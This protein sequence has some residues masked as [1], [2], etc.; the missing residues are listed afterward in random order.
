MYLRNPA[1]LEDFERFQ[2]M[3]CND[4]SVISPRWS[5]QL[6]AIFNSLTAGMNLMLE[7]IMD[8]DR[9]SSEA[10]EADECLEPGCPS[11]AV[12]EVNFW[13]DIA[14]QTRQMFSVIDSYAEEAMQDLISFQWG[15]EIAELE[16]IMTLEHI[17][18]SCR[19]AIS[20]FDDLRERG[21]IRT[22]ED[23]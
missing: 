19:E 18:E 21:I 15:H 3:L 10:T 22:E 12:S 2:L 16:A 13:A 8:P 5:A 23:Y 7:S 17:Q 9:A 14:D 1:T 20:V 11:C 6:L 4:D